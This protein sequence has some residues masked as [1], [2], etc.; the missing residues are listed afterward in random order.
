MLAASDRKGWQREGTP[1]EQ[2]G[3]HQDP[4]IADT[5][6][7]LAS[8]HIP[9][10]FGHNF[11]ISIL[12]CIG[13]EARTKVSTIWKGYYYNIDL[14]VVYLQILVGTYRSSSLLQDTWKWK[15]TILHMEM[16]VFLK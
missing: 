6:N 13:K 2:Y 4:A 12:D 15:E 8:E 3:W 7:G 14:N 9:H 1:V 16:A 11:V 10:H 5:W